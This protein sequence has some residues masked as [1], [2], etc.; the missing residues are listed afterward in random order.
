MS[1]IA[2]RSFRSCTRDGREKHAKARTVLHCKALVLYRA[3]GLWN[4]SP[5]GCPKN[6]FTFLILA[7]YG[8]LIAY[9]IMRFPCVTK[10][11]PDLTVSFPPVMVTGIST[12]Q[13]PEE[14]SIIISCPANRVDGGMV[15]FSQLAALLQLPVPTKE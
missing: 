15:L 14:G 11:L 8:F 5:P 7:E 4:D 9:C 10:F 12:M 3:C 13:F 2:A 1:G 6:L